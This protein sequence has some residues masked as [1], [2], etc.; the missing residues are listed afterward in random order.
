M[1]DLQ[2][3]TGTLRARREHG[4]ASQIR[5]HHRVGTFAFCSTTYNT[6]TNRCSPGGIGYSLATNLHR[7][8]WRVFATVRNT[9][10]VTELAEQGIETVNLEVTDDTSIKEC[11]DHIS[12]ATNGRGL[13]MLINNAGISYTVPLLDI[14]LNE[15]RKIFAANVFAVMQ[16]CQTFAPLLIKAKGTIVMIGSLAGVI[17]YV[18]GGVYNASKAALHAYANTLRVEL[19]PL[20]VKVITVVTGGVAS[21]LTTHVTRMLPEDSYYS[22]LEQ[23]YQR[24]QKHSAEVGITPDAYAAQV[25]P[26]ILPGGGPWPWRWL[27]RDARKRW[28]WAGGSSGIVWLA[29]G[30]WAWSGLFDLVFTMMFKINSIRGKNKSA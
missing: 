28:I 3:I 4:S 22:S 5:A 18:F 7:R 15:A 10:A 26:Q 2:T 21:M 24:R 19:Q 17:P 8:G 6:N 27:M 30:A 20:D 16:I 29:S 23:V 1:S 9:A 12:S 25:V 11:F 14:D 13:D